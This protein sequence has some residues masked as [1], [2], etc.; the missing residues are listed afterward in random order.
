MTK[1][2]EPTQEQRDM[3]RVMITA[4]IQH[5]VISK[6]LK[7]SRNTFEKHF[8]NEIKTAAAEAGA[9]VV[10]NLFRQATRDDPKAIPAAIFWCKT[11]LRWQERL[12]LHHSGAIANYDLSKL[13]DEQLRALE[14]IL[15]LATPIAPVSD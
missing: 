14:T 1:A 6:C 2:Y 5:E 11:R 3:V 10:A 7:I 4:G 8:E 9:K 12:D 15:S 13:S